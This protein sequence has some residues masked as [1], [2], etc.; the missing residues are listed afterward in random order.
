MQSRAV[1]FSTREPGP[2]HNYPK[3][4][5]DILFITVEK[6]YFAV[7]SQIFYNC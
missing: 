7:E 5:I 1:K 4:F 2:N 3:I 6:K